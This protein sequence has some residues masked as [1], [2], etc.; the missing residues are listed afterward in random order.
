MECRL[1]S[2]LP[3]VKMSQQQLAE[4]VGVHR[5]TITNISRNEGSLSLKLAYEIVDAINEKAEALGIEKRWTVEDVW[6]R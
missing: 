4:K 2:I 3:I 1:K 5:N 6:E